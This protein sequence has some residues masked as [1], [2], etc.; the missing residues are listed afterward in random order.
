MLI[1]RRA[2][3][4]ERRVV[5][6]TIAR[7]IRETADYVPL[8]L[9][10][11]PSLPHAFEP[12]RT[13]IA[14]RRYESDADWKLPALATRYPRLS[15][16]RE[17]AD[18]N[19]LEWVTPGHPLFEAL[20][21]HALNQSRPVFS[22]G[23]CF[24]SLL[25][26]H[27]ARL[28][29]YRA[30]VVDGLG[31]VIHER[32]FVV[33]IAES[34]EPALREPSL[35]GDCT[36]A[37][38]PKN[39]PSV[40]A[41]P[42]ATGWLN[43]HALTPFLEEVRA[44]RLAEID[45]IAAHVEL[46]LTELL[47]KADEEIGKAEAEIEKKVTGAEGRFAQAEARHAEL[48]ERREKRRQELERQKALSL[49]AV[50]RL[51]SVLILPHPEREAPDVRRFRP[52]PEVEE[53]AMRV[54]MEFEKA[55][56]RQVYDVHEKNLG[57]DITSLDLNSGELRLI[58]VKGIGAVTGTVLLTPN[59]RRVAEDRRDCYWPY[60]VTSCD[61][62]ACLQ[63]PIKDPARFPWHEVKKVDHYYLS[64][65]ALT[66]PMHVNEPRESYGRTSE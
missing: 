13:P 28:D 22:K 66:Q 34:S 64:V 33:E 61:S 4:Q 17:T 11:V 51:A 30:R 37:E 39:L 21:R 9:K 31:N 63:D 8:T 2:R 20:R 62:E 46:S 26:D 12:V 1:E 36:P 14:L 32:L 42:E 48:M 40:A 23:A 10:P 27:P 47:Q 43:Q 49:Q 57:Y 38:P 24:H 55:Q 59:E 15:T 6:E 60:V 56:N 58:E 19:N 41:L 7:F 45:R 50:E 52:D 25:Y 29:F 54:V 5:P 65:D 53:A 16:D 44:E 18:R 35:L 3:A